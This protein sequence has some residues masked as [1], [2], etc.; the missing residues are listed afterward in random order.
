MRD[1]QISNV[2]KTAL[3]MA[4]HLSR[5]LVRDEVLAGILFLVGLVSRLPYQSQILYHWDSVN[6]AYALAEFNVAKEQPQPPGYI[7]YVWLCRLVDVF[8]R[9][10]QATM[11]SISVVSSALAVVGLFFLGRTMFDR[12]TGVIAALFLATSPLFWFYGEIALPHTLDTLLVIVTAWWCY[13][14]MRADYRYLYPAIVVAAVA[15]GVRQQTLVFLAPMILFALRH[16]GWKRWLL[17]GT[18]GVTICLI[19]FI[20]LIVLSGGFSNYMR[21]MDEFSRRFQTTTS[22][23]LGAGWAGFRRNVAKL[24]LYTLY[25]WGAALLPAA[26]HAGVRLR[27]REWVQPGE[28]AVFLLLWIAPAVGFYALIHMGQQGLVFIFLPALLILGAM[29]LKTWLEARPRQLVLVAAALAAVNV[30]VFCFLPEYPLGPNTQRFLTRDTLV[31]SDRYYRE[32]FEAIT[33]NFDPASTV[34]LAVNWHH[35]EYYLPHYLR[36]PFTLTGKWDQGENPP[37]SAVTQPFS[38]APAELGLRL[39]PDRK[40]AIVIFDETL[41]RYARSSEGVQWVNLPG[42]GQLTYFEIGPQDRFVFDG[43]SF[44]VLP[45]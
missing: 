3:P 12:R 27:R 19:W 30:S 1:T 14:T 42:D 17:A 39:D 43:M 11:V 13:Q 4:A 41:E 6:F 29:G 8:S 37:F 33:Q 38:S 21:V 5:W 28:R 25:G 22:V 34:I 36:L 23:F 32:R 10:A 2:D 35:V 16:A 9:D 7:V 15:G 44:E 26:V 45:H 40:G 31:N 18:I 24:T 20:P